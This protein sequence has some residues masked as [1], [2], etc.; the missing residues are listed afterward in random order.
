MVRVAFLMLGSR[1]VAEDAVQDAFARLQM[2][3][4]RIDNAGGYLRLRGGP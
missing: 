1:A 3:A 4:G 2:R